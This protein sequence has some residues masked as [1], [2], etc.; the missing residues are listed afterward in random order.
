MKWIANS[1][2]RLA[3]LLS[4]LSL[5]VFVAIVVNQS[6][7]DMTRNKTKEKNIWGG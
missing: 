5:L 2:R 6:R 1:E 3:L 7:Q 4:L